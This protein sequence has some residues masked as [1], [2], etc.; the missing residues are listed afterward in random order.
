[1]AAFDHPDGV[2]RD[3]LPDDR[4]L[5]VHG[6]ALARRRAA[7]GHDDRRDAA[8]VRPHVELELRA[9]GRRALLRCRDHR[10]GG[11][12]RRRHEEEQ[13]NQKQEAAHHVRMVRTPRTASITHA[14]QFERSAGNSTT[15]RIDSLPVRSITRRSI[16]SPIPPVGGM[17]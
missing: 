14:G 2:H 15:S 17:P 3:T 16:P 5:H 6:D 8:R 11:E 13:A 7:A 10:I 9:P 4:R 1:V 12:S